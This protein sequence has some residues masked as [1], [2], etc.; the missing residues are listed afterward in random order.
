MAS[1]AIARDGTPVDADLIP[2]AQWQELKATYKTG[3][4]LMDCCKA[5]A[6]LKTSVRGLRFFAHLQDECTTAPE[7]VWHQEGKEVILD[8][9]AMLGIDGASE[10]RGGT[11]GDEWQADTLFEV[12]ERKIAIELQRS[13]QSVEDYMRRQERYRRHQIECFWL[14]RRENV[15]SI[16]K[17]TGRMRMKREWGGKFPPGRKSFAPLISDFPL[18]V[19]QV[20]EQPGVLNPGSTQSTVVEWLSAIIQRRFIYNDGRWYITSD[21]ASGA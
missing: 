19:L 7:T 6:V 14:T 5:P 2:H 8:G 1:N 17:T 20:G 18:S 10:V 13:Y 11:I 16:V 9:L 15:S 12:D 3:D 21:V 4:L